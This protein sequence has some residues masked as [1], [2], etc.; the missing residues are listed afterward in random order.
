MTKGCSG[1]GDGVQAGKE[2]RIEAA[3]IR[4]ATA[5]RLECMGLRR[6]V[7]GGC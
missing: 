4:T 5:R 1:G 7:G 6:Y 2:A 3:A